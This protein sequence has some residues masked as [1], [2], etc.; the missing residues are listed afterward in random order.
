MDRRTMMT[1]TL[2]G[3]A[4]IDMLKEQD[5]H[6]ISIRELCQRADVNRSTFYKY[7]GSQYDL[8]DDIENRFV[9]KILEIL[10]E[11]A[12]KKDYFK[13]M[14]SLLLLLNEDIEM[15]RLIHIIKPNASFFSKII[16]AI[17]AERD[18]YAEIHDI[19]EHLKPQVYNFYK[20]GAYRII[21][22]WIAKEDR[23]N[24]DEVANLLLEMRKRLYKI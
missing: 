17:D 18:V 5:I 2:L 4:L 8:L 15:A 14:K 3:K 6:K 22:G 20:I 12:E 13:A 10:K 16:S 7:Y 23:S 19:P 11:N 21:C 9:D 1:K 24:I